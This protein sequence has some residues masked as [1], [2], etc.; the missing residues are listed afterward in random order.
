[1]TSIN[2]THVRHHSTVAIVAAV[3]VTTIFALA[4]AVSAWAQAPP[5]PPTA[6]ASSS[7]G[8][9]TPGLI[10]DFCRD[11]PATLTFV[12]D[13]GVYTTLAAPGA[14]ATIPFDS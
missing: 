10:V 5:T 3:A 11:V 12:L 6:E 1:M 14:S 2:G 4:S 13:K 7:V 9:C 8:E